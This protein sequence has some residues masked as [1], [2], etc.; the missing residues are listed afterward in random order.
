MT[1]S[2]FSR[3]VAIPGLACS[4]VG[5]MPAGA[6][7]SAAQTEPAVSAD[8]GQDSWQIYRES[9]RQI[10][11]GDFTGG[12][13]TL[14]QVVDTHAELPDV[15]LL[16]GWM[17]Q[18]R[19]LSSFRDTLHSKEYQAYVT[20]AQERAAKAEWPKAMDNLAAAF[21][22]AS[23][24]DA[25]RQEF[26]LKAFTAKAFS[27]AE[28]LRKRG[29]WTDAT[30][31]YAEL[32][33]VFPDDQTYKD[34]RTRCAA[35]ASLEA[36][37]ND[38]DW[39]DRL[40][41]ITPAMAQDAFARI[42]KYYYSTPDIKKMAV[43]A[44]ERL[45]VLAETTALAKTSSD[46]SDSDKALSGHHPVAHPDLAAFGGLGNPEKRLQFVAKLRH[47]AE[48]LDKADSVGVKQLNASLSEVLEAN[49]LTVALPEEVVVSE[50]VSGAFDALDRYSSMIWP[51][52]QAEFRKHTTGEFSGVGIQ[53][54]MEGER[55]KVFSPLEDT[56]AY[57]AGVE[58]GDTIL[59]IDGK[60]VKGITL[61]QA[62][63]RITGEAG[64]SVTLTMERS[65]GEAPFDVKMKRQKITVPTVKGWERDAAGWNYF[66]DPDR[67]IAFVRVTSFTETT[68]DAFR[69]TL[70]QLRKQGMKGLIV[71]LRLNPG[72]LLKTAVEM[73][74]LFLPP[75][76]DIVSTKGRA[77]E[78]WQ[79]KSRS[80]G[81]FADL[82]LIILIND[83]SASASEIMAGA[84]HAQ[85]RALLV[86]ERSWGKG[87][88]Q[89]PWPLCSSDAMLKLTTA[90]Y[91][92]PFMDR[93]I[94][95]DEDSK[96][97]GVAPDV[98]V[99]LTPK[100][101]RRILELRRNSD[102]LPGKSGVVPAA[103]TAPATQPED[104]PDAADTLAQN[105]KVDPQVET[106]ILLM[107]VRLTSK[108][109]WSIR[110]ASVS[111]GGQAR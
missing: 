31:I 103:A 20:K 23:S 78:P 79:I 12:Y 51:A 95:R 15:V 2:R 50:Y 110:M 44:I 82:P 89:N 85:G 98:Q 90:L 74:E 69:S 38:P 56:P 16:K 108:E 54:N 75:G 36:G 25:F 101:A 17:D 8:L 94:H 72:G 63:R 1:W 34:L 46:P 68:T 66:V 7:T 84:L 40:A 30:R 55:I 24:E 59:S 73:C 33:L 35:H 11:N 93:S 111:A 87:S 107:R 26:W 37:Y 109:P 21:W 64:T 62:V 96:E 88:V 42:D 105:L 106:S 53:I 14:Q 99:K 13:A 18:Y 70:E 91:Y 104:E 22:T 41:G 97:W 29:E 92:L 9:C 61:E 52:E 4:L 43:D 28:D 57:K 27:F 45:T 81:E 83:Y 47:Q 39:K 71:D 10:L 86:G 5:A 32:A 65:G 19:S 3:L 6:A 102:V 77:S 60:P 100:E 49:R 80:P 58:P 48:L 76:K 67:K